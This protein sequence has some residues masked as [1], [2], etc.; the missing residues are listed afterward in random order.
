MGGEASTEGEGE[1]GEYKL[2]Q[3][4]KPAGLFESLKIGN[5]YRT[6]IRG[7]YDRKKSMSN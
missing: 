6:G 5:R 4:D 3:T 1:H 2:Q 7:Y